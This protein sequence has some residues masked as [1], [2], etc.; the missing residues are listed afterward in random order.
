MEHDEWARELTYRVGTE[1]RAIRTRLGLTAQ[2]LSDKT[3]ELGMPVSRSRIAAMEGGK[4]GGV[5]TVAELIVLARALGVPPLLLLYPGVPGEVIDALPHNPRESTGTP[6]RTTSIL[7]ARWFS[8]EEPLY[9]LTTNPDG[10]PA[11][12]CWG[13]DVEQ[14]EIGGRPLKLGRRERE[15]VESIAEAQS[16]WIVL[17]E[18][19][20]MKQRA[21]DHLRR[22]ERELKELRKE[23]SREG[24]PLSPMR[25]NLAAGI[26]EEEG[27]SDEG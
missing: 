1:V 24:L 2:Q 19:D 23:Q 9:E 3:E 25:G 16:E 13:E 15:L 17:A 6:W 7:A 12:F 4:R 18:D 21:D 8:G 27:A 20:P 14:N 26:T 5:V 10:D 22:L 11:Y